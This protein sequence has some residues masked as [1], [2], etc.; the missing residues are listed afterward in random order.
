MEGLN[1]RIKNDLRSA[2]LR[3]K[4]LFESIFFELEVA[5]S[6]NLTV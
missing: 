5:P 2:V 4:E 1:G 3:A 6:N